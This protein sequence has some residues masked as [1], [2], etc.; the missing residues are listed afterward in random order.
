MMKGRRIQPKQNALSRTTKNQ[1]PTREVEKPLPNQGR[2]KHFRHE[3]K[4]RINAKQEGILYV[5][6]KSLLRQ[7]SHAGQNG[8]YQIR[9][10]Y[11]D[12]IHDTCLSDN[13][14]GKD[15]RSKFRIRYYDDDISYLRLEK[16]F[17][18]RGLGRKE[19][20]RLTEEEC[21]TLMRGEIPLITDAM[22]PVKQRLLTELKL[23]GLKPKVIVTYE[24]LPFIYPAGN[25]RITFDRK[26]TSSDE[27]SKF[28]SG[29]YARRPVMP[30]G[31]SIIEVKWDELLPHHIKDI[32]QT[33]NLIQTAFSK[34]AMCRQF[35]LR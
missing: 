32:L 17:K 7:D 4:Y 9:S 30:C 21:R 34:Y 31:E 35:C 16:K 28:L 23:R 14:R 11:F 2:S 24:R 6:V 22:P 26:L 1:A 29:D 3:N 25:V 33:E 8:S 12:D 19:S 20:C 18:Y 27:I 13:L 10:L 5:K 15:P